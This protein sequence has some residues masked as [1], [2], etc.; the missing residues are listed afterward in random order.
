M[1]ILRGVSLGVT[2]GQTLALVGISGCGKSTTVSLVERFYDA[3]QGKVV[4][5]TH[6]AVLH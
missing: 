3:L 5:V 2:P 6:I 4:S 1:P